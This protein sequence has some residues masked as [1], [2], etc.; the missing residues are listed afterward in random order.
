M[1]TGEVFGYI[2]SVLVFA[3]FY[4][5]TMVPLRL[6]AMASNVAFIIYASIGGLA[7]IL[8]LH[9]MLLPLNAMRLFQIRA[10]SRQVERAAREDF[11]VQPL[12]PLMRRREIKANE[13]LFTAGERADEL[14]YVVDG[15][16]FLPELQREVGAGAFLG[17]FAL[18]AES[19]RRSATAIARTD[20]TLMTLT[21]NAVFAAL[22]Q[23]P[24]LGIHLLKLITGRFLQ[25]TGQQ[26][27]STTVIE[28]GPAAKNSLQRAATTAPRRGRWVLHAAAI[29]V[30]ALVLGVTVAYQPLYSL[31]Y[32]DAV[33]TT[34][35]HIASAPIVGT[36]EGLDTRLGERVGPG[37]DAGRVVNHSVDRSNLIRAE[38]AVRQAAARQ[39]ELQA[40]EQRISA[41]ASEWQERKERYA[42]GF[43]HDLDLKIDDLQGRITLLKERVQ[44][45]EA[46]ARRKRTLRTAGNASLADEEAATSEQRNLQTSLTQAN[47]DLERVRNRRALAERGIFLQDD[48]KEPEWSWRSLDEIRLEV[49]RTQRAAGEAGEALAT[50]QATLIEERKNLAATAEAHFLVPAGMTVWSTAATNGVSVTRGQRLFTWIDCSILLVD[51]PVTETLAVLAQ[52][53]ARAEIALEGEDHTREGVV[54]MTRGSSSQLTTEEL[55][56]VSEWRKSDAQALV[57]LKEPASVPG[58]PIGR[59]AFVRF[60]DVGLIRYIMAWLPVL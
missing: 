42:A 41:L 28:V 56:T 53:G 38:A 2:A 30:A 29:G 58:C 23:H 46:S 40:Y 55:A 60:P 47:M 51:V 10:F 59:R 12:L 27:A 20:A 45:A 32:R 39:A 6:V 48:G 5:R 52:P 21:R 7:P 13:T 34:W 8:I 16:L 25:N 14:Y 19:G 57:A 35:L 31:I 54:L 37:G 33:V 3:T 36:V 24:R 50:L 9:V 1:T 43:R 22:L 18:F 15:V 17:E 26:Q 44:I 11:S 49:A 4:M